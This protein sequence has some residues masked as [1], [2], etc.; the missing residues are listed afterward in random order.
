MPAEPP[1][2]TNSGI[3]TAEQGR[4]VRVKHDAYNY[5]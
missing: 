4:P 5:A 1:Q 3:C 2:S